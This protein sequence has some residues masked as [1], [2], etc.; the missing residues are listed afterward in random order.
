MNWI[1]LSLLSAISVATK[2]VITRKLSFRTDRSVILYAKYVFASIFAVL[3]LLVTGIPLIEPG[4]Y[5]S[6]FLASV[7]DV[8]ASW[9]FIQAVASAQLARTFPLVALTPIFL[10]GTSF[11]LLGEVPSFIGLIGI[12]AIVCGAYMLRSESIKVGLLEPFRLLLKE[13]A[14][15]NMLVAAFLFSF[16]AVFFKKAILNSS[17]YFALCITQLLAML[18]LSAVFVKRKTIAAIYSKIKNNFGLLFLSGFVA[19]IAGLTL[20][21]AFKIGLASYV[22]SIKRTSILFTIILGYI[23]FKEDHLIRSLLIGIIMA[24]GI[25]LISIG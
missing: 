4:F 17:V 15:R 5:Y 22:V 14:S 13:K 6:I 11:F 2:N 10:V 3:L 16:L 25:L 21:A 9:Y 1:L 24:L 20:F 19:F 8:I 12:I 23:F 7:I 18:I